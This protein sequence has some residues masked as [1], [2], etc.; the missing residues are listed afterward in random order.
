MINMHDSDH[1]NGA[2]SQAIL[3]VLVWRSTNIKNFREL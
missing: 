2:Y 3:P 1:G